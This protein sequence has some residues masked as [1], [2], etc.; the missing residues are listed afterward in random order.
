MQTPPSQ[1]GIASAFM[2]MTEV[3]DNGDGGEGGVVAQPES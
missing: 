1:A 3:D 2:S